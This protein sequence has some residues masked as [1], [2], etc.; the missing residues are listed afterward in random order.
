ME[1]SSRA[2]PRPA[3]HG[4]C[5]AGALLLSAAV[6]AAC[7]SARRVAP[8]AGL[9]PRLVAEARPIG[10]GASFHPPATGPVIGRCRHGLGSRFGV[11]VELFA[12][13]RV[14]LVAAGMGTRPPRSF[15][16]GRISGARCYGDFVTLEPTGVVLV[17][18]GARLLLADLFRA[19]GQPLTPRRLASFSA[20]AGS[21]VAVF[22]DG[23]RWHGSPRAVPLA[24]HWEIVVEVGPH[25]PPHASYTF[26]PGS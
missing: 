20:P 1:T 14:V 22:V 11:H 23:R 25:V 6:L 8:A 4:G 21:R 13:D 2:W 9:P 3:L 17:R 15:S 10:R 5:C 19:W 12:A 16:A 26:P 18:P 7:G 24:P